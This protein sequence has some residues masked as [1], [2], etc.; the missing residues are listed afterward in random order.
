MKSLN[1]ISLIQSKK[2]L[3]QIENNNLQYTDF[4]T[5]KSDEV[6]TIDSL[7]N[8]FEN[9]FENADYEYGVFLGYYFGYII[10]QIGK[11]FDLLRFSEKTVINIELKS[12]KIIAK[13]N[14]EWKN[15]IKDQIIRNY[16]YLNFLVQKPIIYTYVQNNGFYKLSEDCET[17][18]EIEV[19]EVIQNLIVQKFLNELELDDLFKPSNYLVSPF[20]KV[21][22]FL[23][24]EYFLT[25]AQETIY[26]KIIKNV[27]INNNYIYCISANAGTGKTL[28]AYHLGYEL[29][30]LGYNTKIIHCGNLN[31]GQLELNNH[32]FNISAI[33]NI[34]AGFKFE[35]GVII[36][37][38]AHRIYHNQLDII[39]NLFKNENISVV[40][41]YD[42][43]QFLQEGESKD[44]YNYV[45]NIGIK[46]LEQYTLKGKIRTNKSMASFIKNLYN[47]KSISDNLDYRN[48]TIEYFD[49]YQEARNYL[50]YLT[51]FDRWQNLSY[52]CSKYVTEG[53]QNIDIYSSNA[54]LTSHSVIGQEFEK[55]VIVMDNSFW[56]EGNKLRFANTYYSLEGMFYQ[57]ITRVVNELKIIV[58]TNKELYNK[59][60]EIKNL[61]NFNENK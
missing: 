39:I 60:I 32:N 41:L 13:E 25:S 23:A 33:K 44:I 61:Q 19:Q 49:M 28:L 53:I 47:F 36:V 4:R 18:I 6:E 2:A 10:P 22:K 59:L 15:D 27:T 9:Y 21:N 8:E 51:N 24:Q 43:K 56:Y 29:K 55:V 17:L 5:I 3:D 45:S 52:T 50:D 38:E 40:F 11:E 37:D 57:N 1:L 20:N 34:T 30:N 12:E 14:E 54:K 31:D 26:K 16:Y 7:I 58:V 46:K 42:V 48:I 35:E